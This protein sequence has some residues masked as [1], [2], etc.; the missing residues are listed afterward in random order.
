[1]HTRLRAI[2]FD[3]SPVSRRSWLAR[4]VKDPRRWEYLFTSC[5]DR[6]PG[7]PSPAHCF[8]SASSTSAGCRTQQAG[9]IAGYPGPSGRAPSASEN[10]DGIGVLR[11]S[12]RTGLSGFFVRICY[13]QS[14][15]VMARQ[16]GSRRGR[17]HGN[18]FCLRGHVGLSDGKSL[19]G[20][21]LFR[22]AFP[23]TGLVSGGAAWRGWGQSQQSCLRNVRLRTQYQN[24]GF[25]FVT[26][27]SSI[28][29]KDT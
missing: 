21:E 13:G 2:A 10:V 26:T 6:R 27:P 17:G 12:G 16:G 28:E 15:T 18:G 14:R 3:F 8:V 9:A 29:H 7:S 20:C 19:R 25:C 22:D 24:L 5:T 1:M 11:P 23:N 4:E